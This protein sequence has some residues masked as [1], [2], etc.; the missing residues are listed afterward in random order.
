MN[1]NLLWLIPALPAAGALLNGLRALRGREEVSRHRLTSAII[2]NTATAL[3]ALV[4]TLL[5]LFFAKSGQQQMVTDAISWFAAGQDFS[6]SYGLRLDRLSATMLLIVTWVGA[7]VHLFSVEYMRREKGY[8]RYFSLL[9]LFMLAMLL[10]ILADNYVLMFLGWEGVGLASY[11]LIGFFYEKRIAADAGRKAFLVN[12][13]ADVGFL[14]ALFLIHRSFGSWQFE[15]IFSSTAAAGEGSVWIAALLLVAACGKSAQLPLHVWLPDAMAGPTPVSALMHAATMVTAGVYLIAR[16]HPLFDAAPAVMSVTAVIG[17]VT[18]LVGAAIALVQYDVKKILAYS[19]ISQL[20]MMFVALGLGA[21]TAAMFHLL[22]HAF[23]KAALFLAAGSVIHGCN[24]EQDIRR[25]GG[26]GVFLPSTRRTFLIGAAA[27]AGLPPLA[28]FFSKD[29]ILASALSRGVKGL[30]PWGPQ[31]GLAC[32]IL[33]LVVSAMTA[34]YIF[35]LYFSLFAGDFRGEFTSGVAESEPQHS[36]H[37]L[38]ASETRLSPE[39]QYKGAV[40]EIGVRRTR[41]HE[42]K[43]GMLAVLGVLAFFSAFTGLL[44]FPVRAFGFEGHS[45]F[46]DW[47]QPMF[48]NTKFIEPSPSSIWLSMIASI[49]VAVGGVLLARRR[50]QSGTPVGS[51]L[52]SSFYRKAFEQKLYF[53]EFYRAS[54]VR[55]L[56]GT[57]ATLAFVDRWIVDGVV[58]SVGRVSVSILGY[59]SAAVDRFVVDAGVNAVAAGAERG[60]THLRRMQSG[61]LQNYVLI[62][63][64]G[65]LLLAAVYLVFS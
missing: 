53:D 51:D 58:R 19:T 57:S 3:T 20:G 10:L 29:E 12:R 50:Y 64:T 30:M 7:L 13:L 26:L 65:L 56:Y 40:G 23:F 6:A 43:G 5:I 45:P 52:R 54:I 33:G 22:T 48:A 1:P 25:L 63:G 18:A 55:W 31:L 14:L 21:Y 24:G 27:L 35:R 8:A 9:N 32:W 28:G 46:N 11:L 39:F 38:I 60:S 47:L 59:G 36:D 2:A 44:G 61:A 17:I 62:M 4:S 16:S 49:A 34:Y 42:S 37:S 15:A 41:P